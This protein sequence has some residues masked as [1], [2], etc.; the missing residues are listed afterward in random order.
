VNDLAAVITAI[1]AVI[2]ACGGVVAAVIG[3]LNRRKVDAAK[4]AAESARQLA[5]ASAREIVATRDGI[6]ELGKRI[7]GQLDK[8]LSGARAEGFTSGEQ[9]QRDRHAPSDG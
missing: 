1:A 7:D 3:Y 4:E 2:A 9:A 6:F 5:A 8:L